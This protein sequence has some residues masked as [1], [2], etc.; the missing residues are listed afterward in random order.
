ML[1]FETV[2]YD[3]YN[4]DNLDDFLSKPAD[5]VRKVMNNADV[6]KNIDQQLIQVAENN[7]RTAISLKS[8]FI[9]EV[10]EASFNGTKNFEIY[11]KD[12][13]LENEI[14]YHPR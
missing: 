1:K 10:A 13:C 2:D 14:L 9:P 8:N 7:N 6:K 12:N 3:I 11:C 5:L 4:S